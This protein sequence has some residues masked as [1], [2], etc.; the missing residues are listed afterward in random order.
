MGHVATLYEDRQYSDDDTLVEGI[1]DYISYTGHSTWAT[2]ALEDVHDYL[3]RGK[4]SGSC[5]LTKEITSTDGLT[6]SAAY[7]IGYLTIKRLVTKYGTA[8]MLDFW[9]DVERNGMT[10][11]NAATADL[12]AS[13]QTVNSDC[14]RYV[15]ATVHA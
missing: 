13:W 6:A 4:W 11:Q 15:H 3:K 9:G 14:A 12:G 1:A 8:K 5:L 10:P 2:Y 7:G